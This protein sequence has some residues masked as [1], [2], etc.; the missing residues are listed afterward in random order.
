MTKKRIYGCLFV[1]VLCFIFGNSVLSR[2]ASGAISHFVAE[3]IGKVSGGDTGEEG[4]YLIRK[5]AH[6]I[7]FAALGAI[8][9][10]FFDSLIR[11]KYRK[12]VTISFVGMA[13]PLIDETIQIFSDRGSAIADVWIDMGGYLIG[14]AVIFALFAVAKKH[15]AARGSEK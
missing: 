14:T 12:Y 5:M 10:L 6:L 9:H 2:E 11:D 8:S 15:T 7:E 4:H 1:L 13:T 3:I